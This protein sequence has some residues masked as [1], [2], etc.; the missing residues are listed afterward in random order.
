MRAAAAL[1]LAQPE[2]VQSLSVQVRQLWRQCLSLQQVLPFLLPRSAL[3]MLLEGRRH[4]PL[5]QCL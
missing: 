1:V 4:P 2:E 5:R 3:L